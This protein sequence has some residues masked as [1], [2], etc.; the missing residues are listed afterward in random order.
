MNFVLIIVGSFVGCLL[1][2]IML[3]V[4]NYFL[5]A[6]LLKKQNGGVYGRKK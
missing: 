4:V 2:N 5:K 1:E 3:G 6:R